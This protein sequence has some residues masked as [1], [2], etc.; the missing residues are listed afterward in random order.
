MTE[1]ISSKETF[2][3][4]D[5]LKASPVKSEKRAEEKRESDQAL[6]LSLKGV[7]SSIDNLSQARTAISSLAEERDPGRKQVA[8]ANEESSRA[9]VRDV[10]RAADLA[11]EIARQITQSGDT[12]IQVQGG[13]LSV[14][15]DLALLR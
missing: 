8:E 10:E 7:K 14:R 6:K 3:A 11:K 1:K 5:R 9:S 12:A 2:N 13:N 15:S 4:F